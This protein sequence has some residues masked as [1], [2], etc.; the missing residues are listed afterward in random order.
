ME[1]FAELFYG[2]CIGKEEAFTLFHPRPH[3]RSHH[4]GLAGT[5]EGLVERSS[6]PGWQVFALEPGSGSS[7]A[8]QIEFAVALGDVLT[9]AGR[10]LAL[11]LSSVHLDG[12]ELR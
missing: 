1:P 2:L 11:T 5:V 9:R 6:P 8:T 3:P 10:I 12:C 7:T 4:R